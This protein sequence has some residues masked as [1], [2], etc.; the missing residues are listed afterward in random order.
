[1]LLLLYS[2]M[3]WTLTKCLEKS[4]MGTTSGCY[5]L[6]WTVLGSNNLQNN[7]YSPPS[8][9]FT[10]HPNKTTRHSGYC[11]RSTEELIGNVLLWTLPHGQS[12]FVWTLDTIEKT[13]QE[14]WSIGTYGK[15]ESKES[16]LSIWLDGLVNCIKIL[17]KW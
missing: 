12:R 13:Y 14:W 3:T 6:F 10:N 1:M 4:Y 17:A 7:S 8:L 15:R 2:C 5:M 11:W 16:M 9:H